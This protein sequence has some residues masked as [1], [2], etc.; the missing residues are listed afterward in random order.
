MSVHGELAGGA[1]QRRREQWSWPR[2]VITPPEVSRRRSR[3][4]GWQAKTRTKSYG[5]RTARTGRERPGVLQDPA[6]QLV[7]EHAGCPCS[8]LPSLASS[9]RLLT[10]AALAASRKEEEEAAKMEATHNKTQRQGAE[11]MERARLLLE[12]RRKRKKR[13][14]KKLRRT[15]SP[16]SSGLARRVRVHASVFEAAL[17][18]SAWFNSGYMYLLRF[19]QAF[20]KNST[21][22][23]REGP[24]FLR[25]LPVSGSHL[26]SVCV[27]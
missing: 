9:F 27:A 8:R 4:G 19:L 15:S 12:K 10:A 26:F 11:A 25:A 23:Q 5:D 20:R 2:F 13:R 22:L 14:K 6:L 3:R 1:A 24:C 17:L 7:A 16:C 21:L 18:R